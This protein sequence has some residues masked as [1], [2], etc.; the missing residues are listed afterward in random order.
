MTV[1][2]TASCSTTVTGPPT[3]CSPGYLARLLA[4]IGTGSKAARGRQFEALVRY[5]LRADPV[6]GPQVDHVWPWPDWPGATGPDIGIDLVVQSVGGGLWAVQC[7]G[8]AAGTTVTKS[9]V[10]SFLAASATGQFERR[11][12]VMSTD[13]LAPNARRVIR[14]QAA[15]VTVIGRAG[16]EESAATWPASIAALADAQPTISMRLARRALRDH[17][18]D[19]VDAMVAELDAQLSAADEARA[20][21]VMA[22]GTGKTL[23]CHGIAERVGARR[24]LV[25]LPSLSLL[26]QTL[27]EWSAQAGPTGGLRAVAVCGDPTVARADNDE[28]HVSPADLPVPV[29]TNVV[30]LRK[31]L[32]EG[33]DDQRPLAVFSTYHS[34]PVIAEAMADSATEAFDLVV[35]DEAHYVAGRCSAAFATVL[36]SRRI[37]TRR[38]VFAT[39]TP[40]VVP[41]H[42]SRSAAELDAVTSSMDDR[43]VF[44][45]VAHRLTFGEA[46]GLGLL[47]DYEVLVLGV[48]AREVAAHDRARGGA[49]HPAVERAIVGAA[50]EPVDG[51]TFA[52]VVAIGRAMREKGVRTALSFHSRVSRA[53]TFAA[54]VNDLPA[55]APA[56]DP[57]PIQAAHICG[58]MP[59]SQRN[60]LLRTLGATGQTGGPARTLL[61]NARCLTT[62]V[63]LPDLDAVLFADPRRSAVDIVQAVGRA[64]RLGTRGTKSL[65][66]LPVVLQPADDPDTALTSSA[67]DSVWQ[68]LAALRDHDETFAEQLDK[69]RVDLGAGA[70]IRPSALDK[71]VLDL[72]TLNGVELADRLRVRIVETTTSSFLYG[73]GKLQRYVRENGTAL[74]YGDHVTS[75]GFALGRWVVKR[76]T[77]RKQGR[78]SKARAVRLENLPGW[79]WDRHDTAFTIGFDALQ[80]YVQQNGHASP[81]QAHVTASGVRLG[82]WVSTRRGEYRKGLLSAHRV[83]QLEQLPGWVWEVEDTSFPD[84][85]AALWEYATE[86]GHALVPKDHVTADG[87]ALGAWV[88]RRRVEHNRGLLAADRTAQLE[89]VPGWSWHSRMAAFHRGLVELEVYV[90][91]EGHAL[92]PRDHVTASGFG[93]GAWVIKRRA[94]HRA[95]RLAA[96]RAAR[97]AA[98]PRWS[99]ETRESKFDAGLACLRRYVDE[100]GAAQVPGTYR[101]A[102]GFR[103]G[104]WVGRCRA[105]YRAGRL[106][107]HRAAALESLP[108]WIWQ[109]HESAFAE[110]LAVLRT[111]VAQAGDAYVPKDHVSEEGF[112]LGG[113]VEAC[114]SNRRAGQLRPDRIAELEA[115]P[116]WTWDTHKTRFDRAFD[117]LQSYVAETGTAAVPSSHTTANGIQLG[118]WAANRRAEYRRGTLSPHRRELLEA[119]PGWSWDPIADGFAQGLAALRAYVTGS[120]D[121]CVPHRYV[122]AD[123][124]WLGGWVNKRRGDRR[125]S[126]LPEEC[127][128]ELEA[129]PGWSWNPQDERF[130]RGITALTGYVAVHGHARVAVSHVTDDGFPLGRWAAKRRD[131]YRAGKITDER[132]ALLAALPGWSWDPQDEH[133]TRGITA[134]TGYVAVHGHARVAVSHVT[135]DGFPLGRWAAKRRDE[136]RA[137]K[138]TNER[139]ALL[140]ALPGW[141]WNV[142]AGKPTPVAGTRPAADDSSLPV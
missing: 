19:A 12:L 97:L 92:V 32:A 63:D 15:P 47:A 76:R 50:G 100:M 88:T 66:I 105:D 119:L 101:T 71:L 108:G 125:R 5:W 141:S 29:L 26:A 103:L 9:D 107:A 20:S 37:R 87:L 55:V 79:V 116:G 136:Y 14:D 89:V 18:V 86:N 73:F 130:T 117:A 82:G 46:I 133:F 68:V 115:L 114:R 109:P 81:P 112:R 35:A 120:G 6:W 42:L 30:E 31:H 49:A 21:L 23:T 96:N 64:L 113:W 85:L 60:G 94:D 61:A 126:R 41:A 122:T 51:A 99:W 24:M 59:T 124:F 67:F 52:A 106:A 33:L 104:A 140:A 2:T 10:D 43:A 134:L 95:G 83:T 39:A 70:G 84:G 72:P 28:L 53:R 8:Y 74:V 135:D 40:R 121:A 22:C 56:A 129:L 57:G 98:L 137:G 58:T 25:L 142:T 75:D 77:E 34:S 90:A 48:T 123:G 45:P 131:E 4:E 118:F 102:D 27:R 16:L 36:D 128:A 93:L 38:R 111:Y 17:Q 7:K 44:G 62:G 78:L 127:A 132:V 54:L 1:S 69:L 13:R 138:I 3:P 91:R 65:I 139:A 80:Q 11:L 110:G